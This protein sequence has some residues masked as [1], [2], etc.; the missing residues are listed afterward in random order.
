MKVPRTINVLFLS[1]FAA[2]LLV[3]EEKQPII[4]TPPSPMDWLTGSTIKGDIR[5][6]YEFGD[7]EGRD[8]SHAGTLR[9]RLGLLSGTFAGV[10]AF[11]EYEGTVTAD[12]ESYQAAS[13]HGLGQNKTV[14][15]DPESHELNQLWLNFDGWIPKSTVKVGRQGINLDGQRYVGTVAWRQNMQT[16]DAVTINSKP[17]DELTMI[18]GY[19]NHVDRIFG[20]GDINLAG[21]TD[22]EGDSHIINAAYTGLPFGKLTVFGYFFDLG[23]DA[24]DANSNQSFGASL[25]GPLF[26]EVLKY[27]AEYGYQTDAFD[28]PLDYG[29]NYFHVNVSASAKPGTAVLGYEYLG[30]D[31]G[32]G[33]K[34]PLATLHKFNGFADNFLATPAGGLQDA[35]VSLGTNLPFG[36]KG[37]LVYH[38]FLSASGGNDLGDEVDAVLVK[39]LSENLTL[40]SKYAYFFSDDSP[41]IQRAVIQLDYKF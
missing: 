16:F 9:A 33:Y 6:R 2:S 29:A 26:S 7:Q 41:D 31:N 38:K 5:P 11:A 30:T 17:M 13:V 39:K 25:A 32:V 22:F 20:S 37:T 12:R 4:E 8:S 40:L 24:G 27:Y 18:Y 34:F 23:N 3:A 21:Q 14:I 35:Y 28:S 10:Q 36:F 15:A 19:F 1:C